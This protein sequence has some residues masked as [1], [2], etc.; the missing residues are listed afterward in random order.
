M[1][2]KS[3][4]LRV[5]VVDDEP[6]IRWSVCETLA[7]NGHQVAEAADARSALTAA[8]TAPVPFDVVLLDFRLPDSNDLTL[9]STLRS[10]MPNAQIVLMT[11]FGS[12][13]ITQGAL[14][15]GAYSVVSKPFEVGDLASLILEAHG[16]PRAH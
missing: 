6:L 13:E 12:P 8:R 15:L 4:P 16:T 5:L 7:E 1:P 9:L 3:S 10:L 11:A 14:D 2:K